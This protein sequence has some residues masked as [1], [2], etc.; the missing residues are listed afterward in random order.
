MKLCHQCSLFCI[1]LFFSPLFFH[2]G[3][4]IEFHCTHSLQLTKNKW[5]ILWGKTHCGKCFHS[6]AGKV[7][8][9]VFY[10]TNWSNFQRRHLQAVDLTYKR[11]VENGITE[12]P[13]N[14]KI[15]NCACRRMWCRG[16]MVSP[17][18]RRNESH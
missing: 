6:Q 8:E 5:G 16:L 17:L 4:L 13:P 7:W 12:A 14:S 11:S 9:S 10:Y 2:G 3:K 15:V 18:E 1:I